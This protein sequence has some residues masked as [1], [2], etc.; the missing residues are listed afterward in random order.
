MTYAEIKAQFSA[1]LNRTDITDA[2]TVI[3]IGQCLIRAAR[4]LRTPAQETQISTTVTDPFTG[5]TVPTGFKQLIQ[6]SISGELP[7]TYITPSHYYSLDASSGVPEHY[8]RT[9][10][11]FQ[12]YPA[13]PVDTVIL[14]DYWGAFEAFGAEGSTTKLSLEN[15]DLIIYGALSYA[16]DYYLDER[17]TSFE[18]RFQAI[19]ASLQDQASTVDGEAEVQPTALFDDGQ[20]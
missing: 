10:G 9:N 3:F 15:P 5:I 12:F 19:M 18:Q 1:L 7:L 16:A 4:E 6:I 17:A 2:L 11:K 13:P 20:A 14:T 8:T